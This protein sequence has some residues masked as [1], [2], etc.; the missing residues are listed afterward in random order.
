MF[1][2]KTKLIEKLAS[3]YKIRIEELE[4]IFDKQ[5]NIYIDF[6]NVINWQNCLGWHIDLKRLKQFLNS[7]TTIKEIKFYNGLLEGDEKSL[8]ILNQAKE[9]GYLVR[10][11]AVS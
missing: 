4:K 5:S 10:T 9:N 7:F 6:A 11:K 8:N 3:K 2:P 1:I